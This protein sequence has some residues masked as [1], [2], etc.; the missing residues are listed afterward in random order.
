MFAKLARL[1]NPNVNCKTEDD[2]LFGN[3]AFWPEFGPKLLSNFKSNPKFV[4]LL[5]T[6]ID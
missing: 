2:H 1:R 4:N 6:E 5:M 3:Y